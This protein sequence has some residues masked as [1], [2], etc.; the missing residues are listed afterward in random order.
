MKK[1]KRLYSSCS[2][3]A[4]LKYTKTMAK[5]YLSDVKQQVS[6]AW[7]A[8]ITGS[9]N[10]LRKCFKSALLTCVQSHSFFDE[11]P[12]KFDKLQSET[13]TKR[14]HMYLQICY[15]KFVGPWYAHG[16]KIWVHQD[17]WQFSRPCLISWVIK[18]SF[19]L[20]PVAT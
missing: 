13:K 10:M 19:F 15:F 17:I 11:G 16:I 6:W 5:R 1:F 20:I 7:K 8:L 2:N 3:L 4:F 9:D 12:P 18:S 14:I